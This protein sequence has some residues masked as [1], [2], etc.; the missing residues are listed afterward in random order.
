MTN[1][2]IMK[3]IMPNVS[4]KQALETRTVALRDYQ[5][6]QERHWRYNA[7]EHANLAAQLVA[8][9]LL[10]NHLKLKIAAGQPVAF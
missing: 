3:E 9:Q 7:V 6:A 4:F 5:F 8:A 2:E 1:A 10:V